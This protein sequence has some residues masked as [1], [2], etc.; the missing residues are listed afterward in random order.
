MD[1]KQQQ[2]KSASADPS[3]DEG[4]HQ[5]ISLGYRSDIASPT[6]DVPIITQ[7]RNTKLARNKG[8]VGVLIPA[9]MEGMR[10]IFGEA[11]QGGGSVE[12]QGQSRSDHTVKQQR[13]EEEEE[14]QQQ[15]RVVVQSTAVT[16]LS[17][18]D[19]S[20]SS[21]ICL[22]HPSS[23][24]LGISSSSSHV[25]S[26]ATSCAAQL[27][28]LLPP[29]NLLPH[30]T[31]VT[32]RHDSDHYNSCDDTAS[33]GDTDIGVLQQQQQ[34]N[35]LS[36]ISQRA[37]AGGSRAATMQHAGFENPTPTLELCVVSVQPQPGL[38]LKPSA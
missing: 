38:A 19:N 18:A 37:A 4:R 11:K 31:H 16:N 32:A 30:P 14:E 13:Q 36:S 3:R 22:V 25:A 9:G 12:V 29:P 34:H 33:A 27:L 20:T 15:Q 26:K 21:I 6:T 17:S 5:Q 23:L 7:A 28:Q 8:T 10:G 24:S 1:D 2:L 35:R